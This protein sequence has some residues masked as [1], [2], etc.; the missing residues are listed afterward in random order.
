MSTKDLS[1]LKIEGKFS[2]PARRSKETPP[3]PFLREGER[4]IGGDD[5]FKALQD[6]RKR[7]RYESNFDIPTRTARLDPN[8]PEI[9]ANRRAARELRLLNEK[10]S[11]QERVLKAIRKQQTAQALLLADQALT[12]KRLLSILS[13]N[14]L[15]KPGPL[16]TAATAVNALRQ[17]LASKAPQEEGEGLTRAETSEAVKH[18][19]VSSGLLVGWAALGEAWGGRQRQA[20]DQARERHELFSL[21]VAGRHHYPA[22][23]LNLSAETVKAICL[24]L[25]NVDPAAQVIF[26]NRPHGALGGQTLEQALAGGKLARVAHL[27]KT[28]AEEYAGHVEAA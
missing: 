9:S 19:W 2:S 12:L 27:A 16:S 10:L 14:S 26:W 7:S 20:L 22:A 17:R 21:K 28:F 3:D 5:V 23:F 8:T 25:K 11:D 24:L 6:A 13:E 18:E 4:P 1:R 15:K